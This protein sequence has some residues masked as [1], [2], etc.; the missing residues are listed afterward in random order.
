[1]NIFYESKIDNSLLNLA[2]RKMYLE[3]YILI[4]I[5]YSVVVLF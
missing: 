5:Q 4:N 2:K 1:M 3:R